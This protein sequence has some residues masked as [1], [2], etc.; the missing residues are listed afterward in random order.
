[1]KRLGFLLAT[2]FAAGGL[3]QAP[4]PPAREGACKFKVSE[5]KAK[6]TITGPDEILS[7]VYLMEQPDSPIEIISV[8]FKYSWLT[9]SSGGSRHENHCRVRVRNRS[10]RP[11]TGL[12]ISLGP[13]G[14][15]KATGG[16]IG[17]LR[18]VDSAPR[19]APGQEVEF[20]GCGTY[21]FMGPNVV[22]TIAVEWV[23]FGDCEYYPSLR[24]P[25]E[26]LTKVAQGESGGDDAALTEDSC[27]FRLSER[28]TEPEVTGPDELV[29]RIRVVAQ[30]D[31]PLEIVA[32]DFKGTWLTLQDRRLESKPCPKIRVRNRSDREV[33]N[34]ETYPRATRE[35]ARSSHMLPDPRGTR[36]LGPGEEKE[37]TSC[38]A[39]RGETVSEDTVI[40]L[41]VEAVEMGTCRYD[42]SG[43]YPADWGLAPN[44]RRIRRP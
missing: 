21:G 36:R 25:Q 8:D 39:G 3:A 29:R 30:P 5:S 6:P 7:R 42:P 37:L 14:T 24:F 23:D 10:D 44:Y 38:I 28:T 2:V 12:G 19:L 13:T 35:S 1:M 15:Q 17:L 20:R 9:V 31:S 32:A 40:L 11:I 27:R 43:S 33:T 18:T 22:Y 34:F 41:R 4:Q 26:I 16:D